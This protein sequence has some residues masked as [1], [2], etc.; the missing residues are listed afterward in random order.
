MNRVPIVIACLVSFFAM[1]VS[2]GTASE[3][4]VQKEKASVSRETIARLIEN[5][6]SPNPVPRLVH[7]GHGREPVYPQDYDFKVQERVLEAWD[8]LLR[9]GQPAW[10]QLIDHMNDS[11][12]SCVLRPDE[13]EVVFVGTVCYRIIA[14]QVQVYYRFVR[15]YSEPPCRLRP[16][17]LPYPPGKEMKPAMEAWWAENKEKSLRDLQ[18]ESSRWALATE[19]ERGFS[20]PEEKAAVVGRLN[21]LIRRLKSS[22]EPILV[23][24]EGAFLGPEASFQPKGLSTSGLLPEK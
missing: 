3:P 24:R 9:I 10:P 2:P 8:N 4:E 17:W 16:M 11:R 20:G 21:R 7:Q 22:D 12:F 19:R 23:D 6:A 15:L 1:S 13:Y 5:L 14:V 18:L